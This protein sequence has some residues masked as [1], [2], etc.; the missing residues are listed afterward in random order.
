MTATYYRLIPAN[1]VHGDAKRHVYT[2]PVKLRKP[3]N[4]LRK[5]HSAG[6]F[7]MASVKQVDE[8]A[9]LSPASFVFYLSQDD[10]ARVSLG[11]PISK[12]QTAILMHPEYKVSL[13]DHDFPVGEIAN[14]SLPCMQRAWKRIMEKWD[15]VVQHSLLSG[16]QNTI[17]VVHSPTW[18]ILI[19]N[20]LW[21]I[22]GSLH[23]RRWSKASGVHIRW[24]WSR[25]STEKW[26]NDGISYS[27]LHRPQHA[28]FVITHAPGSST[29]NKVKRRMASLSKFT[30]EIIL[31]F[32]T[33]GSHLD[34][35]NKPVDFTYNKCTSPY[36]IDTRKSLKRLVYLQ[37]YFENMNR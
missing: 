4:D 3:Q 34:S 7:A 31:P 32:D 21:R 17:R 35:S 12:K 13:P 18:K 25:W 10:K 22:Q 8:F 15:T 26:E 28:L 33:F 30:A 27:E 24:W 23:E 37:M 2:V 36:Y 20:Q 9:S 6:H 16:T 19:S 14:C 29:Y 5:K 1:V 11:L